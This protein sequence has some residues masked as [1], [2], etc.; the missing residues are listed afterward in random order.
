MMPAILHHHERLDGRGYPDGLAGERVPMEARIVGLA[1]SFDA[2]TSCRTYRAA[3]PLE[4]VTAEIRRYSGTQ[5]DARLVELLLSLDLEAYVRE[6]R[7]QT[8]PG[9]QALAPELGRPTEES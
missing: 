1:D 6:L 4:T 3:M 7:E 9:A 2:M 8:G 5:F